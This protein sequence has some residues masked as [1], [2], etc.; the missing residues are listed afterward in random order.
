[1]TCLFLPTVEFE[2]NSKINTVAAE[3]AVLKI[4]I[5]RNFYGW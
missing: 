2:P 3:N 5:R 1:M 4:G